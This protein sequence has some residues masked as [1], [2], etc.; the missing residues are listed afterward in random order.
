MTLKYY[1]SHGFINDVRKSILPQLLQTGP[2]L[3]VGVSDFSNM[4][5]DHVAW[6]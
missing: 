5:V 2:I 3:E 1:Y 4:W 6:L